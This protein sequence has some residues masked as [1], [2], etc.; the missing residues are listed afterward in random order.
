ML[1]GVI[2]M[3]VSCYICLLKKVVKEI[4]ECIVKIMEEINYIFNC[5]FGMLLNV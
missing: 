1:V 4:G 5:V 2:K 3:I